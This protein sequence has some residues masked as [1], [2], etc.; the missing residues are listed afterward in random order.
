MSPALYTSLKVTWELLIAGGAP[1]VTG[2]QTGA[3]LVQLPSSR[4]VEEDAP[5][6]FQPGRQVKSTV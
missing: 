2:R 3:A 4:H 5:P 6:I 1:Q